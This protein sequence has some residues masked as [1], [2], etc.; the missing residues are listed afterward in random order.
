MISYSLDTEALRHKNE[1]GNK[2]FNLAQVAEFLGKNS[3]VDGFVVTVESLLNCEMK[4]TA[5]DIYLE[6]C[7]RKVKFPIILR[8]STDFED[9]NYSFAGIFESYVC[10]DV[11]DMYCGLKKILFAQ[12]SEKLKKYCEKIHINYKN[13]KIAIV[14]QTAIVPDYAGVAFSKNPVTNDN[15]IIYVEYLKKNITGVEDGTKNPIGVCINKKRLYV[16]QN[17][18]IKGIVDVVFKL[19]SFFQRP[20]DIEWAYV[21]QK[22]K[23]LQVRPITT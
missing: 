5:C 22:I 8:S 2:A 23:V 10:K 4:R 12:E 15:D 1:I 18:Y 14:I 6:C 17:E 11:D 7:K 19:E 16:G 20:I 21:D 9:S 13:V 3:I